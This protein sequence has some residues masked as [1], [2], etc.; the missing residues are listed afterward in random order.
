MYNAIFY[1]DSYALLPE[2]FLTFEA[3]MADLRSRPSPVTYP[4]IP[5][6]ENN[7]IRCGEKLR[8]RCMAPCFLSGVNETPF[9]VTI[10][11]PEAVYPVEVERMPMDAYNARLREVI[12]R[13]CPGCDG[14]TPI[15]GA[16][17]SLDGHHDEI[18]LNGVC[19]Y[20]HEKKRRL[21]FFRDFLY[22]LGDAFR[23]EGLADQ[24]V[25]DILAELKSMTDHA[26]TAVR[27]N[28]DDDGAILLT[29]GCRRSDP[30]APLLLSAVCRHVRRVTDDTVRP[31]PGRAF[32][33]TP[34]LLDRLLAPDMR[35]ALRTACGKHGVALAEMTWD[36]SDAGRI[37][38]SLE[39]LE[40]LLLLHV[41]HMETDRAVLLL[42]DPA[43]ALKALR[44]R[45]PMLERHGAVI[46]VHAE[47]DSRRYV[48]SFDMPC[49]RID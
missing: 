17:E 1:Q 26:I 11:D 27:V 48:I 6:L 14:Y 16:D 40:N 21:I 39:R 15:D 34:E 7:R 42:A 45:T 25:E 4:M 8:G 49:T 20:R 32:A 29:L 36:G 24:P 35:S 28:H 47:D 31:V 2:G 44:Y 37:A 18:S 46:A 12:L 9:P 22:L 23:V 13:H 38:A 33:V 43:D 5:L 10:H 30:V 3:F 19:F 41:L